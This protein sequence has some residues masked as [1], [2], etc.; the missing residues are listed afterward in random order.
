M[1]KRTKTYPKT[2]HVKITIKT[3]L[4]LASE[5]GFVGERFV[6]DVARGGVTEG[7]GDE[8]VA[9]GARLPLFPVLPVLRL[10]VLVLRT[11]IRF[12]CSVLLVVG[13][14]YT[15]GCDFEMHKHRAPTLCRLRM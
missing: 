15:S 14:L 4:T 5:S 10:L 13:L 6:A 3:I 7:D 11:H 8:A 1:T 9:G 12:V 2:N